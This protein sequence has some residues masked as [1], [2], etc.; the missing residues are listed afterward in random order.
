MEPNAP[1]ELSRPSTTFGNISRDG[2]HLLLTLAED[3]VD[4]R[5]SD[6]RGD[7]DLLLLASA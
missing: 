5:V 6:L 2:V 4:P 7:D 3:A 1:L